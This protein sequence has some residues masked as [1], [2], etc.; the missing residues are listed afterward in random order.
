MKKTSIITVA[1]LVSISAA[2]S[3]QGLTLTV[4]RLVYASK[5]LQQNIAVQNKDQN[6]ARSVRVECGFFGNNELVATDSIW[7]K[8]IAPNTTGFATVVAHSDTAADRVECRISEALD[9]R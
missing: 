4:G 5:F 6:F 8:N 2:N 1:I 3:Q 9:V 7:V